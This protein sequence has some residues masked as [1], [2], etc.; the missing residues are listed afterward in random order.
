MTAE[1]AMNAALATLGVPAVRL[2]YDG[3][4]DAFIT[5]QCVISQ[6]TAFS[7]DGNEAEESLFR[8]DLFSRGDFVSLLRRT[9]QA[10]KY[11]GFYGVTADGETYES[12]TMLYHVSVT[13]KYL[14]E[15]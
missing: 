5:Y 14:E 4:A 2:Q 11:A 10:L 3:K 7:D 13:A 15:A 9:K 12:D 1:E 6:E 8:L